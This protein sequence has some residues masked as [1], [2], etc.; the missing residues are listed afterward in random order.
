MDLYRSNHYPPPVRASICAL[1]PL[2]LEVANRWMLG[3]PKRVKALIEASK[4]LE[5]L[6][7]QET[8]EREALSQPGN[9]HLAHHEIAE[10]YG[11]TPEPPFASVLRMEAPAARHSGDGDWA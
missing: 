3:W 6:Q 8:K 5:R 2:G 10:L 7:A 1:E 9:K 11:L 4:Y